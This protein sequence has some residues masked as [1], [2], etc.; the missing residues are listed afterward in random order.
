[1]GIGLEIDYV[2]WWEILNWIPPT[3]KL[4]VGHKIKIPI[5]WV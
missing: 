1:M 2:T 3:S 5:L 4:H